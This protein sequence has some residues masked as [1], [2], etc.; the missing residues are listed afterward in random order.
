MRSPDRSGS[1]R[2]PCATSF[3][4]PRPDGARAVVPAGAA[5]AARRHAQ[6]LPPPAAQGQAGQPLERLGRSRVRRGLGASG[7]GRGPRR[8]DDHGDGQPRSPRVP[9]RLRRGDAPG[10]GAGHASRRASRRLRAVAPGSS[11]HAECARRPRPR[12]GG[13]DGDGAAPGAGLRRAATGRARAALRAVRHAARQV[14]DLQAH[15]AGRGRGPR[16]PGRQRLRG[17]L[18]PSPP[19]PRGAREFASGRA[20]AT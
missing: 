7:G 20:P 4:D 1:A 3:R 6:R 15:A 12:I 11:P 17:G 8:R 9:H 14:L 13:G 16:M 18:H 19:L 10:G 2:P 5:L